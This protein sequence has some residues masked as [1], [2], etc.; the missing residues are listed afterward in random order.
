M[1]KIRWMKG[2]K[3]PICSG[4]TLVVMMLGSAQ[5]Q[6]SSQAHEKSCRAYVQGFYDWYVPLLK[7]PSGDPTKLAVKRYRFSP[8]LVR[9]LREDWA[10][11]AKSPG[12][13]VGLDFDPF[14]DAQDLPEGR[15]V[16]GKVTRKGSNYLVEV[17]VLQRGKKT[18]DNVV[19][20]ELAFQDGQWSFVNFH[21]GDSGDLLSTLKQLRE[22]RQQNHNHI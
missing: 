3:L 14:I 13:I 4:L 20:P 7:R 12:D 22:E 18:D 10:A 21:Y 8:D 11:S 17:S 9:Q 2:C 16:A 1:A 15:F 6:E 19:V 5:G